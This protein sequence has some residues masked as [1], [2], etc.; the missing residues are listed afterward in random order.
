[1]V[2]INLSLIFNKDYSPKAC[3]NKL[4][5]CE[6]KLEDENRAHAVL[7]KWKLKA[8]TNLTFIQSADLHQTIVV[9]K[10]K[11]KTDIKVML[12]ELNSACTYLR[13]TSTLKNHYLAENLEKMSFLVR[14]NTHSLWEHEH[15]LARTTARLLIGV[16]LATAFCQPINSRGFVYDCSD[17]SKPNWKQKQVAVIL[18]VVSKAHMRSARRSRS[19]DTKKKR[20]VPPEQQ[21][22]I[23][24]SRRFALINKMQKGNSVAAGCYPDGAGGAPLIRFIDPGWLTKNPCIVHPPFT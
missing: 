23:R 15:P 17:W 18:T 10:N 8:F 6:E 11:W 22:R 14:K 1:M 4:E 12:A 13:F 5:E 20:S 7:L 9:N 3:D 16:T 24:N 2:K 21:G 19:L